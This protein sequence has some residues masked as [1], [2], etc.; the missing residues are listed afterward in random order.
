MELLKI[1][2]LFLIAWQA[3]III[4]RSCHK[5]S[6]KAVSFLLLAVGLTGFVYLQFLI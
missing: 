5:L 2:F 4:I 3:P 6:V 1:M